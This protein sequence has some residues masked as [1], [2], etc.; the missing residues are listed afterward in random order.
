VR[1]RFRSDWNTKKIEVLLDLP[2]PIR[3]AYEK[4]QSL[5]KEFRSKRCFLPDFLKSGGNSE[6]FLEDVLKIT[7]DSEL[8]MQYNDC[9][10]SRDETF[11]E[12]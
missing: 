8:R 5:L 12:G 4:E 2:M 9:I 3:H 1:E 7:L 6:L 10:K 11:K